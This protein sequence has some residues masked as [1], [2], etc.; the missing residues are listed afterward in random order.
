[1]R[2]T[3]LVPCRFRDPRCLAW[4]SPTVPGVPPRPACRPLLM[5]SLLP[6]LLRPPRIVASKR[7]SPLPRMIF[8]MLAAVWHQ[9]IWQSPTGG[10]P[11]AAL[12]ATGGQPRVA[13]PAGFVWWPLGR[14]TGRHTLCRPDPVLPAHMSRSLNAGF[15]C[16]GR[17]T[18]M[19]RSSTS[20]SRRIVMWRLLA[21]FFTGALQHGPHP[22]ESVDR[23]PASA[24]GR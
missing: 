10:A 17:S 9:S 12:T 5:A 18:A 3:T 15:I 4:P 24:G 19:V 23:V 20:S 2:R 8:C 1:M 6:F 7:H 22:G 14:S 13:L 11:G 21:R 16:S